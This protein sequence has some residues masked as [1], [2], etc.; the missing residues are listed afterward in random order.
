MCPEDQIKMTNLRVLEDLH[1]DVVA[2]RG[3]NGTLQEAVFDVRHPACG[4]TIKGSGL[5]F[6]H[7]LPVDSQ[8][9][10]VRVIQRQSRRHDC[11]LFGALRL[12]ETD[13]RDRDC[14]RGRV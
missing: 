13:K 1:C 5:F 3:L 4:F 9:Q 12:F 11:G 7:L 2:V 6:H 10:E 14:H 8:V